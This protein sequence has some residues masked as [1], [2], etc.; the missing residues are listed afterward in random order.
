[1]KL[2]KE[3]LES[4]KYTLEYTLDK[5]EKLKYL[6]SKKNVDE[7]LIEKDIAIHNEMAADLSF[8]VEWL[9]NG[10]DKTSHYRGVE[11][12]D[13]Y[14]LKSVSANYVE[15]E[16][17]RMSKCVI[18]DHLMEYYV[19]DEDATKSFESIDNEDERTTEEKEQDARLDAQEK[20]IKKGLLIKYEDAKRALSR[21]DIYMLLAH[22]RG[23][24]QEEMAGEL[25]I[26]RQAVSKRIKRIKKKLN[27]IGIERAD[28]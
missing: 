2:L 10:H 13:A 8:I 15:K 11:M 18:E 23:A 28:L 7:A 17:L 27:D 26:T 22:Q 19:A 24:T 12:I 14:K 5:I 9:K 4:Y 1:M 21:D 16:K 20:V 25:N 6:L 3:L